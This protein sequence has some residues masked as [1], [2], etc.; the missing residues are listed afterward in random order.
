MTQAQIPQ[1][2][3]P[4]I[5]LGA[6][7]LTERDDAPGRKGISISFGPF[8]LFPAARTFEKDGVRLALGNRAFD[9]LTVLVERA[10]EV[11]SHRELIER[12]WRGLVVDPSNVR[13]H[14]T[15]LRRA[16][17]DREGKERYIAN[18]TGQ[19][20]CFV[21][22]VRRE[23]TRGPML[24][25]GYP[26]GTA[27]QRLVLPPV[28]QR[29]IGRDEIVRA[30]GPDLIADRF[31][32][33]VGPG[34]IGKTTVAVSVAHS[35][36]EEFADAVCFVD[37]AAVTDPQLVPATIAST[38]GLTV[39]TEDVVPALM[40]CARTL[41][42][43]LVL[44]NCEHVIDASATLAERVFREAPGVHILV[45]SREALRVEGEHAYWLPPLES[46]PPDC[47]TNAAEALKFPAVK[48]FMER[49]A[50]SGS[51]LEMSDADAATV[52]AIC[53][54]LDGNPLAIE[55]A[56][57]RVSRHG[58]AGTEKLLNSHLSLHWQGRRTAV[59][60][61]Q[62]LRALLDW[63][64]D[65]LAESERQALRRLAIFIGPFSLEAAQAIACENSL[66]EADVIDSLESLVAKS[67][68]SVITSGGLTRYRLLET[69]RIYA[70]EKLEESGEKESVARRHAKYFASLLRCVDANIGPNEPRQGP[71]LSEHLGNMR[72]AL[73]WTFGD[74]DKVPAVLAVELA[75]GSVPIFLGLS[76]LAECHKWSKA[77][78]ALLDET[79][80]GSRLEMVLQEGL[81]ISSNWT[82][83]NGPGVRAAIT[84]ALDIAQSRRD[85]LHRLRLLA[86][87]HVF[88]IRSADIRGSLAVAEELARTARAA[89]DTSY[90]VVADLLLGSSHHFMG[91]Q[92]AAL[93]HL[94]RGLACASPRNVELFGLDLHIRALVT[95]ARVLWVSGFPDRA[96]QVAREAIAEAEKSSK[97]VNL[98]F[99]YLYTA[100]V[101]LWRGDLDAA[102]ELLEKLMTHP[103]WHALPSLH[104]TAFALQGELLLRRGEC[105]RGVALLRSALTTMTADRQ[106]L[107]LAR[108]SGVL[109]EGLAA[110][111]EHDEAL[112]VVESVTTGAQ[113]GVETAHLPE[114]LRVQGDILVSKPVPDEARAEDVLGRA[115]G[116]AR[117]QCALAW[118][119]RTALTLARIRAR[120]GR[121]GEG[122]QLLS[123][124]Y[125]RFAEGF[126][127]S[128]LTDSR[129]LL[130]ELS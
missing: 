62:T 120:Q 114:L 112:A 78:L 26:C 3:R 92:S 97:P 51:R 105:E 111:G 14:I 85:T 16:L 101:F 8:R 90:G 55:I 54:R 124:V 25:P 93:L 86:G 44:D 74:G 15:G 96:M 48:L 109:A 69:T 71:A 17:G 79:T 46:P 122:R 80:R 87:L 123:S 88:L 117:R 53:G 99:A 67:L 125:A 91:D 94:Q 58:I 61:H 104:A 50:A 116:D 89:A 128:D 23:T 36:L 35:M 43:L 106:N 110:M 76:L 63:S 115:L 126:E 18:V 64:Y 100:Q 107:L 42:I 4:P 22:P 108:A 40:L 47:A 38:L 41:R 28:L 32:T 98:C 75:A 68:V 72:A 95:F 13:V 83:W 45:T 7:P 29:M 70:L 57:S 11:V 113:E 31:V 82:L 130:Q 60:R 129:Q 10:G 127:T 2:D 39:Q 73:E 59:P 19:G 6:F 5:G 65:F 84:R 27:R 37:I 9:I 30:I 33:I 81:A 118:E 121:G 56:A 66:P 49:A 103:N 12:A 21:A 102:Q 52:A 20:Y 119:L 77:A 1:G 24:V 34:G